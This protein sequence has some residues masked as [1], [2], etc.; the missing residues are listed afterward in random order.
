MPSR[1]AYSSL[2]NSIFALKNLKNVIHYPTLLTGYIPKNMFNKV[3]VS[4]TNLKNFF[5]DFP[6]KSENG[7][8]FLAGGSVLKYL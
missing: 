4:T 3:E 8:M 5:N 7:F 6:W 2:K 1:Q